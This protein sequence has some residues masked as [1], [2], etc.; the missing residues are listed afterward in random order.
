MVNVSW[1][2]LCESWSVK[3]L[4]CFSSSSEL[5]PSFCQFQGSKRMCVETSSDL[6][7]LDHYHSLPHRLFQS[8]SEYLGSKNLRP[9]SRDLKLNCFSTLAEKLKDVGQKKYDS[10]HHSFLEP[11]AGDSYLSSSFGTLS[12][13]DWDVENCKNLKTFSDTTLPSAPPFHQ[14]CSKRQKVLREKLQNGQWTN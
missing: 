4:C 7:K 12:S 14:T 6:T 13:T 11:T 8:P 9:M 10:V 2:Y 5:R 1:V 3:R